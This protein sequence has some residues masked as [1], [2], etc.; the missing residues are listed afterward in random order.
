MRARALAGRGQEVPYF[1]VEGDKFYGISNTFRLRLGQWTDDSSM[2]LCMADS[3]IALGR[4]DGSDMRIRFWNWW[5]NGYCNA[6][7][8]DA[9][10]SASVGWVAKKK[11]DI[12]NFNTCHFKLPRARNI[13][14]IRHYRQTLQGS[15]SAVSQSNIASKYSLE[16][17]RRDL[18]NALL[19]TVLESFL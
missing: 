10:R 6:F 7:G 4:F 2:G 19:C 5:N 15:F 14:I 17:S 8:K 12:S 13:E 11:L 9:S 16:S 18:H 1:D 3:L